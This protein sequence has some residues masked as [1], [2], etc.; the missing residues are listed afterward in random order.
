MPLGVEKYKFCVSC[1]AQLPLDVEI[2][3]LCPGC[4]KVIGDDMSR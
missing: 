1:R 2:G 3:D 4:G